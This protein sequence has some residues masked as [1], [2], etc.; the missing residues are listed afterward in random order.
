MD[1]IILR[2]DFLRRIFPDSP[3]QSNEQELIKCLRNHYQMGGYIPDISLEK[4]II[5]IHV[6]ESKFHQTNKELQKIIELSD[7]NKFEEAKQ[8]IKPIIEN[9]TYNSE[10]YRIYGQILSEE[11]NNEEALNQLIDALRFNPKN[12]HAL[13]MLG[14]I[15]IRYFKDKPAGMDFYNR[16]LD[17]EPDNYFALNNIGG[18]L[19]ETGDLSDAKHFFDKV[20]Q[21]N[22]NY[23]N[24]H[25]G[26]ALL[27]EKGSNLLE[28][29]H[30]SIEALKCA[31]KKD[32]IYNISINKATK[33]AREYAKR[34]NMEAEL[35]PFI[36]QLTD[37]GGK[38]VK[39][40]LDNSIST[41]AKLEVAEVHYKPYHAVKYKQ[42]SI[43]L[44]HLV[45]HELHHLQF[46]IV[47]RKQNENK[48]FTIRS[49]HKA[50]F[51][52]DVQPYRL[53]LKKGGISDENAHKFL[54][55]LFSGITNQL[56]NAPIDLFIED[57]INQHFKVFR[58]LQFLSLIQLLEV[59][60]VGA[61]SKQIIEFT[62]P[63][64]YRG[65]VTMSLTHAFQLQELYGVD[66]FESF[67]SKA[68]SNLKLAQGLYAQFKDMQPD[69][70][71]GEEYDLID[72]WGEDLTLKPYYELLP[73]K[74][75]SSYSSDT[76]LEAVSDDPLDINNPEKD[77][78]KWVKSQDPTANAAVVMYC[79]SALQYIK[80]KAAQ[81]IKQLGFE[82]AMMGRQGFNTNN[83]EKIYHFANVPGKDFSG[84]EALAWMY[85]TWQQIDNAVDIGADF[86]KEYE[87]AKELI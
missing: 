14:N 21:S 79:L 53:K 18:T 35:T 85:T 80:D 86:K 9:G 60:Q 57:E 77:N 70:D 24:A 42:E 55:S 73:D 82:I 23:P 25:L 10:I 71:P 61:N 31:N 72:W 74:G 7:S 11:G 3:D 49:K 43:T 6:D 22:P 54:D 65:N 29:F 4:D 32:D 19:A 5:I 1:I 59:A 15:Y 41:P 38:E 68:R 76:I 64:V 81:E 69:R 30:H 67:N 39:L 26:L 62:P 56:Y 58:P 52:A 83:A 12:T 34:F 50:Q 37:L 16:I 17:I 46:I 36:R 51:I 48:L 45:I 33:Y 2:D 47:A 13:L 40:M 28:A 20:L 87:L 75:F 44:P 27:E 8:L 84:L 63:N 78:T 66:M